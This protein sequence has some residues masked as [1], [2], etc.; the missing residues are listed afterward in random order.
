MSCGTNHF[1]VVGRGR[2][3]DGFWIFRQ[4]ENMI[5]PQLTDTCS[6]MSPRWEKCFFITWV[7]EKAFFLRLKESF[8]HFPTSSHKNDMVGSTAIPGWENSIMVSIS[9]RQA[10]CPGLS[11]VWSV[12][13]RK[14]EFY[15]HAIHLSPPEST[16]GSP[17]AIHVLSCLCDNACKRSP[18]ICRV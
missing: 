4:E 5:M 13:F 17:K 18:A 14:V 8:P 12:C 11:P 15:Q 1:I 16:T 9:V 3:F 10:V 2:G 6:A 7:E